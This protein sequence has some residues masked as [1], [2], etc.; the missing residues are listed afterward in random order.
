MHGRLWRDAGRERAQFFSQQSEQDGLFEVL[1]VVRYEK[2]EDEDVPDGHQRCKGECGQ[3]LKLSEKNFS[4][5][6]E[7]AFWISTEVQIVFQG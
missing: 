7:Y 4:R 3:I 1:Q 5:H 2:K 6:K